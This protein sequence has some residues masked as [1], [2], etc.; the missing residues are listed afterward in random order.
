ME[1]EATAWNYVGIR[2]QFVMWDAGD[3]S[4]FVV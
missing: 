1:A 4:W 3:R 2:S